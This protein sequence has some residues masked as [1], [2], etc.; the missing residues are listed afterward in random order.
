M[1]RQAFQLFCSYKLIGSKMSSRSERLQ[2]NISQWC[3][4]E[5][6][7][8]KKEKLF[9]GNR[10]SL[11]WT[12]TCKSRLK[13]VLSD[14]ESLTDRSNNESSSDFRNISF[15]SRLQVNETRSESS[16]KLKRCYT[17]KY[18]NDLL[19]GVII[20]IIDIAQPFVWT[21]ILRMLFHLCSLRSRTKDVWLIVLI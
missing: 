17:L 15:H 2:R 7:T 18:F 11:F 16:Q 4:V 6:E 8:E 9:S 14:F 12:S 20:S 19:F 10:F 21:E 3:W 1:L 13:T 5:S